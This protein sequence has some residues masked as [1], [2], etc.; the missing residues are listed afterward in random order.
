MIENSVEYLKKRVSK[1]I[2]TIIK[3]KSIEYNYNELLFSWVIENLY[4]NAVDA[5]G[6]KGEI[7]IY[8]YDIKNKI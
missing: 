1:K 7:K 4:K 2:K 5:I 3:I 6:E 8:L